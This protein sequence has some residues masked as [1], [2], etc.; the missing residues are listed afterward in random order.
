MSSIVT[1]VSLSWSSTTLMSNT[2]SSENDLKIYVKRNIWRILETYGNPELIAEE[3]PAPAAHIGRGDLVY[4]C[5]EIDYVLELKWIDY[6]GVNNLNRNR[7]N[8]SNSN[9]KKRKE[10]QEQAER[11][12]NVW[13]NQRRRPFNVM[14]MAIINSVDNN[15]EIL[16]HMKLCRRTNSCMSIRYPV[17]GGCGDCTACLVFED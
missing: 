15:V 6:D 7:P 13:L 14:A 1:E 17:C 2:I 10:V 16:K 3:W 5:D 8:V 11:Y 4:H 12:G 9:R